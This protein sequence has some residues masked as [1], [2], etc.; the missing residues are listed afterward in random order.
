MN[1]K[2]RLGKVEVT[3]CVSKNR[4]VARVV[5]KLCF[6]SH[7]KV[8]A[9]IS[10]WEYVKTLPRTARRMRSHIPLRD[11]MRDEEYRRC[12]Q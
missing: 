12:N 5:S 8:S 6:N 7:V 1:E 11:V 2:G 10:Q 4:L 3:A 9:Q